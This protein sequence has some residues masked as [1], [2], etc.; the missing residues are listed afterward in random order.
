M[1]KKIIFNQITQNEIR[2]DYREHKFLLKEQNRGTWGLGR[3]IQLYELVGM[4]TKHIREI[5]WT[6]SDNHSGPRDAVLPG[7]VTV[8]QCKDAAIKY[9]DSILN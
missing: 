8:E 4:I 7:I 2:F 1:T 5:G 3:A 9:I 6:K